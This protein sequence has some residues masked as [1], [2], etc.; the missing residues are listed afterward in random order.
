MQQ[1][2]LALFGDDAVTGSGRP[3]PWPIAAPVTD[4]AEEPEQDPGQL[5]FDDE[6]A[7]LTEDAA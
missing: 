5:A 7:T 1:E 6:D 4:D 3:H 2:Q